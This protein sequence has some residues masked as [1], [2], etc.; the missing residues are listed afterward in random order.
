[1]PKKKSL[2]KRDTPC[3]VCE[4]SMANYQQMAKSQTIVFD[5][6]MVSHAQPVSNYDDFP[7][8]LKTTVCPACLTSSNEYSFGVDDYKMF[9][10]SV[11]RHEQIK[12]YFKRTVNERFDLLAKWFERFE[13]DSAILDQKHNRPPHTR[14]RATFEKIWKQKEK[15]GVPFF[16]MIFQEPRDYIT[17]L[18]GFALDRYGQMIR[19]SFDNNVEPEKWDNDSLKNVI[20]EHFKEKTLDMKAPK[21]RFYYIGNN[22]LQ[23][24]Q[25]LTALI[26]EVGGDAEKR[27][28]ELLV[29]FWN[30]AY[31]A[32]KLSFRNDDLSAIPCEVLEGGMNLIMAKLHFRFGEV[33]EG[34]KC[35]RFAK[36]Y[37]DNRMKM[38]STK[39]QQNFVNEVDDLY[40]EKF[41]TEIEAKEAAKAKA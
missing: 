21:P 27:H 9:Y 11:A 10:R 1:M 24:I 12:E 25:F 20:Y 22:Y 32:M 19:I 2:W 38:I 37:A 5:E 33:E 35:L 41:K 8:V 39:N 17:A 18:V 3:L 7:D 28:E 16:T 31:E 36:N 14:T 6:W 30:E 40:K 4:T 23:A 29:D 34:M 13:K 26:Q 15:Y